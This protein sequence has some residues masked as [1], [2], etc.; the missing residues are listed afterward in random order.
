MSDIKNLYNDLVNFYNVNDENFKEFMAKIYDEMLANHR[1]VKYVKEH[2]YEEIVK[3]LDEYLVDG[4]IKVNIRQVVDEFLNNSDVI[5]NINTDINDINTTINDMNTSI[6]NS[7]SDINTD[8]E[9]LNS[10]L[11][12]IETKKTNKSETK[13]IQEQID[14]LILSSGGDSNLEVVQGRTNS[15][16]ITFPVINDR[17]ESIEKLINTGYVYFDVNGWVNG[18]ISNSGDD[19]YFPSRIRTTNYYTF[20]YEANLFIEALSDNYEA[21]ICYY[22]KSGDAY[23]F[24]SDTGFLKN[25]NIT[26]NPNYHYRFV[27]GTIDKSGTAT[28]DMALNYDFK[29]DYLKPNYIFDKIEN[30]N[31]KLENIINV[32]YEDIE[33]NLAWEVGALDNSGNVAYFPSRIRSTTYFKPSTNNKANISFDD[34]SLGVKVFW[35]NHTDY[36][37]V[38]STSTFSNNFVIELSKDYYYKFTISKI[39]NSGNGDLSWGNL[40]NIRIDK[41][42]S[43]IAEKKDLTNQINITREM[44]NNIATAL[45]REKNRNPFEFKT[46]DKGYISIVFDDLRNDIDLVASIFAEFNYPLCISAIPQYLNNTASGLKTASNGFETGMKMKAIMQ[47]V[48]ENG[49]EIFSHNV[50]VVTIENQYDYD[51]MYN[52]YTNSKKILTDNGFNVRGLIK[53][54]GEGAIN[55][56]IEIEKWLILNYDYSNQGT[57][58]NYSHNREY[59]NKPV[60]TI[61]N[62]ISNAITNK[63]WVQFYGHTL[64]GQEGYISES[65]LREILQYC[66]DNNV[67]IVTYSYIFDNYSSTKLENMINNI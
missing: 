39:D 42:P 21:K 11:D 52:Y 59:L 28:S 24:V 43:Y 9:D 62:I 65:N 18:S 1:D 36:T 41:K 61:K 13:S 15:I 10:Q 22:T 67:D 5:N 56:T 46:F 30:E 35:Y 20:P 31:S 53:A 40:L 63:R 33:S 64:S 58:I 3:I 60:N 37:Y 51:F 25:V 47:K 6:N 27:L 50:D 7:I 48:V 57:A 12:N 66:K 45:I 34:D 54:G 23:T 26:T 16:G 4:K 32:G 14:N 49:G 17:L 29:V 55:S 38:G 44:Q 19:A 2:L 8:I